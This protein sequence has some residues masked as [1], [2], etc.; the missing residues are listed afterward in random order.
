VLDQDKGTLDM[1]L[2]GEA[3]NT[4]E[5][6]ARVPLWPWVN[7][8]QKSCDATLIP[9]PKAQKMLKESQRKVKTSMKDDGYSS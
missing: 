7:L 3:M 2:D 9:W 8:Y 6:P 5:I 4:V 1:A